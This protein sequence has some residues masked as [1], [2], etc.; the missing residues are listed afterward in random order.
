MLMFHLLCSLADT[1]IVLG[2]SFVRRLQ[3]C[4]QQQWREPRIGDFRVH[5]VSKGGADVSAIR[6]LAEEEHFRHV[7]AVHVEIGSNDLASTSVDVEE[8]ASAIM[9]LGRWLLRQGV[10]KVV[11]GEI[12]S[13]TKNARPMPVTV[14]VYNVRVRSVNALLQKACLNDESISFRSHRRLRDKICDDGVHLTKAGQYSL[15]RN[16]CKLVR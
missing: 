7:F 9:R 1:V 3:N 15:W 8:V 10:R 13:R 4:V 5:F 14:D 12:L 2:H 16:V 6:R 11:I